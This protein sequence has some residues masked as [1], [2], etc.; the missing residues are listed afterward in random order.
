MRFL[1]RPSLALLIFSKCF[2]II[3]SRATREKAGKHR[4]SYHLITNLFWS[5]SL[6]WQR[7]YHMAT[8]CFPSVSSS[9]HL[10]TSSLN[11]LSNARYAADWPET[12]MAR[13][14]KSDG[15]FFFMRPAIAIPAR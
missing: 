10:R 5:R 11:L 12:R 7:D 15:R 1:A 3:C 4:I 6:R 8:R 2:L 14:L 9:D 13:L